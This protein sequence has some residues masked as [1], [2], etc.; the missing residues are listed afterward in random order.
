MKNLLIPM[1]LLSSLIMTSAAHAKWT[2]VVGGADLYLGDVDLSLDGLKSER[3]EERANKWGSALRGGDS[4]Q[5]YVDFDGIRKWNGKVYY[6]VL[7]DYLIPNH[8]GFFSHK[9][10]NES[11]CN[12]SYIQS[13]SLTVLHY[14]TPMAEGTP[15]IAP[16]D[17][18]LQKDLIKNWSL[19]TKNLW[20]IDT[21]IRKTVFKRI[22]NHKP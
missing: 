8:L 15:V 21:F 1:I 11:D 18:K 9:L 16:A 5:Y 13:R 12:T 19:H 14:R 2:M 6:W 4:N 20:N 17:S 10:Y 7:V 3:D 22:C